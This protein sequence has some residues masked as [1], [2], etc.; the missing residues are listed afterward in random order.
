MQPMII[1]STT[2]L[3]L[4]VLAASFAVDFIKSEP[5]LRYMCYAAVAASG[6]FLYLALSTGAISGYWPSVFPLAPPIL[7]LAHQLLKKK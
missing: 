6:V 2:A 1:S 4:S 7:L 3:V 5:F